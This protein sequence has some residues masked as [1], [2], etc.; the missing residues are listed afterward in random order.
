[1]MKIVEFIKRNISVLNIFSVIVLLITLYEFFTISFKN[2]YHGSASGILFGFFIFSLIVLL[3]DYIIRLIFKDRL[4][5]FLIELIL[6][7]LFIYFNYN[8]F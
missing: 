7:I 1:M 8:I 6:L 4:V 2:S 3:I 5:L